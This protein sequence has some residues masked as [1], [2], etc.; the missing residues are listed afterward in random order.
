MGVLICMSLLFKWRNGFLNFCWRITLCDIF[1]RTSENYEQ[2]IFRDQ[3][4]KIAHAHVIMFF[5]IV[6]ELVRIRG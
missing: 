6:S 2:L 4:Y 3:S 1:V 5:L